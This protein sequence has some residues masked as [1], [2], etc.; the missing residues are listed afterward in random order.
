MGKKSLSVLNFL[1][2]LKEKGFYFLK[3]RKWSGWLS[4]PIKLIGWLNLIIL[5]FG[6]QQN[7]LRHILFA[8]WLLKDLFTK[9][10]IFFQFFMNFFLNALWFSKINKGV[11]LSLFEHANTRKHVYELIWA[12]GVV[13]SFLAH[14]TQS[15]FL[16][17][18]AMNE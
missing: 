3:F 1:T 16:M 11:Y 18:N 13:L 4:S 5:L 14:I 6:A 15:F 12:V 7:A 17:L 2:Y 10:W 8:L 9:N